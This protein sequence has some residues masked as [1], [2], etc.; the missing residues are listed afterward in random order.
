[1]EMKKR[2]ALEIA[3]EY[4]TLLKERENRDFELNTSVIEE[5]THCLL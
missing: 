2:S 1:M 4:L 5:G 3:S